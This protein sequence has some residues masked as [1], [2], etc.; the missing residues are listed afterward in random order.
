MEKNRIHFEDW[1]KRLFTQKTDILYVGK[2]DKKTYS[3]KRVLQIY[4]EWYL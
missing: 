4:K 2:N 3:Y 1:K